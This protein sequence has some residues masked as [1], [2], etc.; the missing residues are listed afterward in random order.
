MF[1][2]PI[3]RT[4]FGKCAAKITKHVRRDIQIVRF[5]TCKL[6]A[7]IWCLT[8]SRTLSNERLCYRSNTAMLLV[9]ALTELLIRSRYEIGCL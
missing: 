6:C 2:V 7:S 1:Y 3:V 5:E 9:V 4:R 8:C